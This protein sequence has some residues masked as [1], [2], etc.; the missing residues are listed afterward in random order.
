MGGEKF[1]RDSGKTIGF[2]LP[3]KILK[4]SND[5]RKRKEKRHFYCNDFGA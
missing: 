2:A 5:V 3:A 1:G 4:R